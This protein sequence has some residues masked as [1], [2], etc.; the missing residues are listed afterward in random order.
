MMS[1]RNVSSDEIGYIAAELPGN[2]ATV[3]LATG[4]YGER[5]MLSPVDGIY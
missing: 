4:V 1:V 2:V 3:L 5:I